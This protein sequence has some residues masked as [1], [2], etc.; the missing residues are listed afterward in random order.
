MDDVSASFHCD[1][2][3]L[4]QTFLVNNDCEIRIF[5]KINNTG[6]YATVISI[7]ISL[8]PN[9]TNSNFCVK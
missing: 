1:F 9:E 2:L 8:F 4:K 3:M 6:K 5:L 7:F